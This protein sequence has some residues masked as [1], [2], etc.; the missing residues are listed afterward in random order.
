MNNGFAG[1]LYS[2]QSGSPDTAGAIDHVLATA[3]GD[4]IYI[5]GQGA[6]TLSNSIANN[7]TDTGIKIDQGIVS[8]DNVSVSGNNNGISAQSQ[9]QIL[10]GRSTIT[11]NHTGILNST[12]SNNFYTYADNSINEN[13][14]DISGPLNT[15]TLQ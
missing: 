15:L 3:N 6:V 12:S 2:P 1:I 4:G 8:I 11:G 9:V 13:I 5:N 7:N 10:L 14:T